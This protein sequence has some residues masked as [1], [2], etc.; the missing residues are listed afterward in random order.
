MQL[1]SPPLLLCGLAAKGRALA[2]ALGYPGLVVADAGHQSG[3][4]MRDFGAFADPAQPARGGA[5]RMRPALGA[6]Q[7]RGRDRDLPAVSRR[8][9]SGAAGGAGGARRPAGAGAAQR[10]IEVTHAITVDGG[11]FRFTEDFQGLEV[12]AQQGTVIAP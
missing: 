8:A 3:G 12:I 1:P 6:E 10:V 5:G 4:R 2:R 11:P 9:R 7:R